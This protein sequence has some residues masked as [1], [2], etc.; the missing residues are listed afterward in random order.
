MLI[1]KICSGWLREKTIN[2]KAETNNK[3]K[4]WWISPQ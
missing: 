1:K 4:S 3:A 2:L